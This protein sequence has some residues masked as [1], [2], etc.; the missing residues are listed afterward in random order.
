MDLVGGVG[1]PDDKLSVLGCRDEVTAVGGPVHGIDLCKVTAEGATGTHDDTG[2]G[3][4]LVGHRPHCV[5]AVSVSKHGSVEG[6]GTYRR[7]Q[8]KTPS[9]RGFSPSD[10]LPHAAQ[11]QYAPECLLEVTGT[12]FWCLDE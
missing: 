2:Q 10:S 7:C 1:V 8:L 3:R 11:R 9:L 4:H 5:R 6:D 12:L